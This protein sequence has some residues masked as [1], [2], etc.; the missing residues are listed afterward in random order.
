VERQN[1]IREI[2]SMHKWMI[3]RMVKV[4]RS[5]SSVDDQMDD[6]DFF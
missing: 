4:M 1:N 6:V 5:N 2:V 3:W